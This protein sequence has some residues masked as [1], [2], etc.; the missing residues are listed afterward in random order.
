MMNRVSIAS[1]IKCDGTDDRRLFRTRR[2][3]RV[4]SVAKSM[5]L[6][7]PRQE[8]CR[9][10]HPAEAQLTSRPLSS[11]AASIILNPDHSVH[12]VLGGSGGSRIF[13]SLAQVLLNLQC[14]L[15]LSEAVER[16]RVHDQ[17]VPNITTMEVGPEGVVGEWKELVDGLKARGHKV[18]LFDINIAIS[19]G[20]LT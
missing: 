4:R 20:E 18:G 15:N 13:P 3:R 9:C 14:G 12:M 11:T 2:S 19:E 7:S 8:V 17:I 10:L 1:K 16:P 6:P 5:E